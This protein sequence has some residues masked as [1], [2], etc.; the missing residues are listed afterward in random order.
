MP[1]EYLP[2]EESST[3]TMKVFLIEKDQ[4]NAPYIK[5]TF[6][7]LDEFAKTPYYEHVFTA[8]KV[9]QIKPGS[10]VSIDENFKNIT[11]LNY[12]NS[13]QLGVVLGNHEGVL[14]VYDKKNGNQIIDTNHYVTPYAKYSGRGDKVLLNKSDKG[15]WYIAHNITMEK[16][17]YELNQLTR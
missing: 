10:I 5:C 16:M 17:K 7:S 8:S 9:G 12:S 3:K 1:R 13:Y 11:K 6:I 14:Y 15:T 4:D 2:A